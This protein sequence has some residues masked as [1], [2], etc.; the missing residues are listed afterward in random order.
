M[1]DQLP[2]TR[3]AR[4]FGSVASSYDRGRPTYPREAATWLTGAEPLTVLEV[5]AGTGKLTARLVELGHD[6][7]ATDPDP[8][9][10]EVLAGSLPGVRCTEAAAEELPV[11]D[12]SV[13]V[14]VCAQAFHWLDHE[15]ALAEI[16][17]V[18]KPDGRLALVWNVTDTRIPWVRRLGGLIGTQEHQDDPA[19]AVVASPLFGFVEEATFKHWQLVDRGSVRDL[20]LSRSGIATLDEEERAAKLAEVVA[21]YDEFGRGMDGMQLPYLARCFRAT[22]VSGEQE[23]VAVEDPEGRR[24]PMTDPSSDTVSDGTD[25]DMLLIDFR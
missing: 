13:D 15:R 24:D 23:A 10:L 25:T 19:G 6:V 22:V 11:P 5:G 21:F 8:A 2:A 4:S 17:R 7:H 18:L 1:A 20:A 3:R 14:V 12:R 9:L 16:A